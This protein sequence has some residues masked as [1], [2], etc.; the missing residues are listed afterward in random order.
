MYSVG[1]IVNNYNNILVWKH[2]TTRLTMVI[3]LESPWQY[4][5]IE[6]YAVY[7]EHNIVHKL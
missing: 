7:Q 3:I 2:M 6:H 5:N 4:R 1:H